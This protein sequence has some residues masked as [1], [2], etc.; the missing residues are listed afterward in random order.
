[1]IVDLLW[2]MASL[3]WIPTSNWLLG[4]LDTITTKRSKEGRAH[5]TIKEMAKLA[6]ALSELSRLSPSIKATSSTVQPRT[7]NKIRAIR[8]AKANP[9]LAAP[10]RQNFK[11]R[12]GVVLRWMRA[13]CQDC[14]SLMAI[15]LKESSSKGD[16][17]T[18]A[19]S[20]APVL[21]RTTS[22]LSSS[23]SIRPSSTL[24]QNLSASLTCWAASS[25]SHDPN[26]IFSAVYGAVHLHMD[27]PQLL[28][29]L[30]IKSLTLLNDDPRKLTDF[31]CLIS[32]SPRWK[33]NHQESTLR[34]FNAFFAL[35]PLPSTPG[36]RLTVLSA[37]AK[38]LP[39]GQTIPSSWVEAYWQSTEPS[40]LGLSQLQMMQMSTGILL[41]Y[42]RSLLSRLP[43][44]EWSSS[45]IDRF[46]MLE[47]LGSLS[48]WERT[49]IS[50]AVNTIKS[51]NRKKL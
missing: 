20:W 7:R 51:G 15:E 3:K 16:L 37:I 13:F 48:L 34:W 18:S 40:L 38:G 50:Q 19:F 28:S 22:K 43:H 14:S 47:G 25:S 1:M 35:D 17:V 8:L 27:E 49:L 9:V 6:W 10:V 31:L 39:E 26:D 2:S 46:G 41:L 24:K 32:K 30:T 4:T 36:Q 23:L 12:E 45:F 33:L 42:R 29:A 5:G 11:R 21:A 44:T